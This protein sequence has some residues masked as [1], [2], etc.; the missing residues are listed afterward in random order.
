MDKNWQAH[1]QAHWHSYD[2]GRMTLNHQKQ[3]ININTNY[4]KC[5]DKFRESVNAIDGIHI[6]AFIIQYDTNTKLLNVELHT[7]YKDKFL[8]FKKYN[9]EWFIDYY[10]V[11]D[12]DHKQ[13]DAA[14]L[15][16]II[17][18]IYDVYDYQLMN[19]RI[20]L[21]SNNLETT[22][23]SAI[24][25]TIQTMIDNFIVTFYVKYAKKYKKYKNAIIDS[26]MNIIDLLEFNQQYSEAAKESYN[27]VMN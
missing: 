1:W 7:T 25:S 24:I 27:N 19:G 12:D 23:I 21:N 14:Y 3:D 18:K 6:L 2:N 22:E 16:N 4:N 11:I 10:N 13:A 15:K 8:T 9:N 20:I 17:D 5:M 26:H